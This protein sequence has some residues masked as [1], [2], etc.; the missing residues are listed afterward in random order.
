MIRPA[1]LT[2]P[3]LTRPGPTRSG[4]GGRVVG[5][6]GASHL[7]GMRALWQ[8]GGWR[9]MVAEGLLESPKGPRRSGT[10]EEMGVR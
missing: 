9:A 4:P 8:S 3:Y 10:P 6:V 1:T 2:P 5:V 7:P